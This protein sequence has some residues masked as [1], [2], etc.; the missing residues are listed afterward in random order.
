MI[1]KG[2]DNQ[3]VEIQIRNYQ[4]P[5]ETICK[6]DSNW[7]LI[8][9]KVQSTKGNWQ[10]VDPALLTSEF[11][12]IIEWFKNLSDNQT[13]SA[14]LVFIEPNLEFMLIGDDQEI[15]T[16]RILFDLEFRPE[17]ADD[18]NEY[19]VDCKMDSKELKRVSIA[20]EKELENYPERATG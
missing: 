20:L 13:V 19:F 10:T 11:K 6:Y 5:Q 2:V 16:I 3:S 14:D 18:E 7:L 15:K 1:F 9:L 8:Y 4:F 17:T 12:R